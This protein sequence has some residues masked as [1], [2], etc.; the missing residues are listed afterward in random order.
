MA[1]TTV[2]GAVLNRG[3]NVKDY[4]AKGDGTTDDTAALRSAFDDALSLL[5]GGAVGV[6]VLIPDGMYLATDELFS[7][8]F[9]SKWWSQ[10]NLGK[11]KF[12]TIEGLSAGGAEIQ[13]SSSYVSSVRNT[14]NANQR[15]YGPFSGEPSPSCLFPI[16]AGTSGGAPA[17][18][19]LRNLRLKGSGVVGKD[20]VA[21]MSASE[22]DAS[23]ENLHVVNFAN[24]GHVILNTFNSVH[25]RNHYESCGL[26]PT[27]SGAILGW[28]AGFP[29][30]PSVKF[31]YNATT[32]VVT[33]KAAV[34]FG[35]YAVDDA[36]P[37][38]YTAHVGKEF[39]INQAGLNSTITSPLRVTIS[40]VS[41]DGV[42]TATVTPTSTDQ[43]ATGVAASF[44]PL[45]ATTNG[46]ASITLSAPLLVGSGAS[47]MVGQLVAIPKAKSVTNAERDLFV[48]RIASCDTGNDTDGYTVISL[49]EACS[50]TVTDDFIYAGTLA[51][52]NDETIEAAGTTFD[53]ANDTDFIACRY[54][55]SSGYS[56]TDVSTSSYIAVISNAG[57]AVQFIS[58][59]FHGASSIR[60]MFA[61]DGAAILDSSDGLYFVGCSFTHMTYRDVGQVRFTGSKNVTRFTNCDV[62]GFYTVDDLVLFYF[63]PMTGYAADDWSV[64]LGN[65]YAKI[66]K[67]PAGSQSMLGQ[68]SGLSNIDRLKLM[69][70]ETSTKNASTTAVTE[71]DSGDDLDNLFIPGNYR[72]GSSPPANAPGYPNNST[73]TVTGG[74]NTYTQIMFDADNAWIFIRDYFS[75]SWGSW[76]IISTVRSKSSGAIQDTANDINT[77]GKH[78]GLLVINS[79]D[80]KLYVARG[81]ATTDVWVSADGG[82]TLT[83]V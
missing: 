5:T 63:D 54:E 4:G 13:V 57:E 32:N 35:A 28:D 64:H 49:Q 9:Q 50:A 33:A 27:E 38:F 60:G 52:A 78:L 66:R 39:V 55:H 24:W 14:A 7:D 79:T 72:W 31:D 1:L 71:L 8:D 83:P 37:Y 80:N 22:L 19:S 26:Q 69:S 12:L 44:L 53:N 77:I 16:I 42:S 46:T 81:S 65:P 34:A 10:T 6:T 73:L 43:N 11:Q 40:T 56:S 20:P 68:R 74:R 51:V 21:I 59:K 18:L 62:G 76:R 67:F 45:K 23:M 2:K 58:C 3:V 75:A 25:L 29:E 48:S 36:V 61:T 82:T 41:S 15:T 17:A 70:D 47:D 30:Q